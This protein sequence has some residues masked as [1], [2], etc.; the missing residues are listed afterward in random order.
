M[1]T[2]AGDDH[3]RMITEP[4]VSII[5]PTYNRANMLGLTLESLINQSYKKQNY[6]IIV[7][8]NNSTDDTRKLIEERQKKSVLPPIKYLFEPRQ[9]VH[10]ARNTAFKHAEGEILYYTDDDMIADV[11]LLKEIVKPFGYNSKI[12]A[13]TGPVLPKWEQPP[14][15]WIL[16]FC[17][18]SLLSLQDRQEYLIISPY[19]C[20]VFSCHQAL[21]RDAFLKAGGFN[22]ENTAGEWIGDGET[23]LNIKLKALGYWFG[24]I[25]SSVTYHMIPPQR[26]T[27]K[28]LNKRLANQGNCD[29]YTDYRRHAYTQRALVRRI[30][31]HVKGILNEGLKVLVKRSLH[32]GSWRLSRAR[33]GYYRS[34]VLYDIRLLT[35]EN[36]RSMVTRNDWLDEVVPET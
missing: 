22:P 14:P 36:W 20:G 18:N 2:V 33:V 16:D 4:F 3:V 17:L 25:S 13:V 30:A 35:D 23:G 9:G 10:Y 32:K 29:S 5:V 24:Y 31:S 27:Q 6:E 7:V 34:R 8:D 21:R 28:Y 11:A 19:D 1:D 26:M 15:Q 12:A